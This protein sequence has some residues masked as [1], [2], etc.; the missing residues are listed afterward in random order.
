MNVN[1]VALVGNLGQEPEDVANGQ[2]CRFS[3][4]VSERIKKGEDWEEYTNW[5]DVIVWGNQAKA[6]MRFLSKGSKVGI[7]GSLRQERWK[8]D[9]GK[10]QS[11]IK[12]RA[13]VVQ[14]LDPKGTNSGAEEAS[15]GGGAE[16]D[17]I[18]FLHREYVDPREHGYNPFG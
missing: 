15:G 4:A 7:Q 6:C 18:P 1:T 8:N 9:E 11:K 10:G 12:V 3:I 5:I 2:G 17:E 16:E 13:Q 14:F